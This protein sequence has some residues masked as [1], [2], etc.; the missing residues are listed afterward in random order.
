MKKICSKTKAQTIPRGVEEEN[1][2]SIG[3]QTSKCMIFPERVWDGQ[4]YNCRFEQYT[5][6]ST[7]QVSGAIASFLQRT[8][9]KDRWPSLERIGYGLIWGRSEMCFPLSKDYWGLF[10]RKFQSMKASGATRGERG[11]V[12]PPPPTKKL[13][14]YQVYFWNTSLHIQFV[15]N[16][17][18]YKFNEISRLFLEK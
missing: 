11:I 15:R 4:Q 3:F 5:R 16:K 9:E 18:K 6:F 1:L 13:E 8:N 17:I 10:L 12:S 2:E 14:A 7:R